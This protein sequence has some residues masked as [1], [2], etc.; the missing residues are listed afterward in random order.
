MLIL[1]IETATERVSVAIGGH[2]GVIGLF[3][4]TRGR[5]HAE[6]L[7]PAI[8]FVCRQSD[9]ELEEISVVAV[10]VGPGLFTGMRVGLAAGK[11]IAQALRVP[12]IGISSLDLLAFPCRHS[13]RVV[14]PVIDAR[15][16]EVFYAMYRQVPGGTQ[17]VAEPAVGDVGDLVADL[18]ARSQDVLL[19]GDGALRYRDE[20]LEDFHAEFGGDAH[21]SAAPLVQLAHARALREDWVNPWEV[22]PIYLRAP[23]AQINWATRTTRP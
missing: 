2:E 3:E 6:T 13:D 10:D 1:G 9:I 18:L 7:V 5:R 12:M 22:E 8:D 14:V 4:V 20:I 17:Q 11:A 19:V 15:R 23:D 16:G 21:P